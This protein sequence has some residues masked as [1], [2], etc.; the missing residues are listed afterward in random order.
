MFWQRAGIMDLNKIDKWWF[1]IQV[2]PRYEFT[3]AKILRGKGYEEFVPT[4]RTKRQ[5]SDR[6]RELDLPLF[7]GYVFCRFDASIRHPIVTTPGVI[8]IVGTG[9]QI[10]KIDDGEIEA[11][12]K[13]TRSEM[14]ITPCPYPNV[15]DRI[16]IGEGPLAGVEGILTSWK[17]KQRLILSVGLIQSAI[18]VEIGPDS[19]AAINDKPFHL[20]EHGETASRYRNS[21]ERLRMENACLCG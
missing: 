17:N 4:Y 10:A 15:G 19:I 9:K 20:W 21:M 12:Q 11:I 13:V 6:K 3:A 18:A 1:A 14:P 16:R 7:T 5:L 8:R 2:K